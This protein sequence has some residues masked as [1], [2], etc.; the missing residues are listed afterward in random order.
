MKICGVTDEAGVLAAIRAGADAIG[1]NFA[2][3]TPRELTLDEGAALAALT[4]SAAPP[5]ARPEIVLVTANL[6]ADRMAQVV[7]AIDP[8]AIQLNGDEPPADIA[9]I[10]RPTWK[11]L[12][13]AKGQRADDVVAV[14]RTFL[15]AGATRILLDA[16][17]G[18]HPGGT[19]T[20][21]DVALAAAVA[22]EVPITIAGGLDP[23]NVAE[24][25]LAI[26]AT[27]VDVATGT[28]VPRVAGVRPRKDPLRVAL[29]TKRARD[30]RRH[31]P[32]VAFGPTPVHAGAAR[33][34]RRRPVGD[35]AR[36]RRPVRAGD[37]RRR[38]RGRSRRRTTRCAT[39]RGSGQSSTS[40]WR[41]T[42]AAPPRSIARTASRRGHGRGRDPPP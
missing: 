41:G 29:F 22:R 25:L 27:G 20:R 18:P 37:A 42:P 6:P 7:A 9:R 11:A 17:G 38:A 19:G 21:V 8:D 3:G 33:R 34:R 10:G 24:A 40:S 26:P 15:D 13:V 23:A 32:N 31:R 14:A 5:D 1:L 16:A 4:R 28:D 35:G 2:P 36:L 30:A 39:T 12:R